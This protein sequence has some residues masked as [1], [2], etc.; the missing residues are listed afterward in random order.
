VVHGIVKSHGGEIT[1]SSVLHHG[2]TIEVFLPQAEKVQNDERP[3]PG[4]T[5]GTQERILLVD[6]EEALVF[7]MEQILQKLGY[8][9][10]A[11]SDS[12][13]AL[14]VFKSEPEGFDLVITDQ[15]MPHMTGSELTKEVRAL[16]PE[17]PVIVCT[18]Y[19]RNA[20]NTSGGFFILKPVDVRML[21]EMIRKAL[22]SNATSPAPMVTV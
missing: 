13:K 11:F 14:E 5:R 1:V 7:M 21:A 19:D 8:E 22:S 10:T 12:R 20:M 16:R 4:A 15:T 18:G 2:T 17:M 9:V 6:D 3:E